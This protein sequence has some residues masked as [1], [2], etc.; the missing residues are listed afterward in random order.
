[1]CLGVLQL[2]TLVGYY[3]PEIAIISLGPIFILPEPVSGVLMISLL[4]ILYAIATTLLGFFSPSFLVLIG[5]FNIVAPFTLQLVVGHQYVRGGEEGRGREE[6]GKWKRRGGEKEERRKSSECKGRRMKREGR[7]GRRER[8]GKGREDGEVRSRSKS[9]RG[10]EPNTRDDTKKNMEEFH[11]TR[12]PIPL[13]LIFYYHMVELVL[14]AGV[15]PEL[16]KEIEKF[17]ELEKKSTYYNSFN[18]IMLD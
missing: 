1:M 17:T 7:R 6:R 15:K 3:L 2:L 9:I 13:I 14:L 12:N 8:R 18:K 10:Y 5:L 16:K 4:Y 11:K